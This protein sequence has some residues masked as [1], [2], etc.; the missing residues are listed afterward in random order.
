MITT[1][2]ELRNMIYYNRQEILTAKTQAE[3]YMMKERAEGL[4]RAEDMRFLHTLH[5][6]EFLEQ[7]IKHYNNLLEEKGA[8]R[9]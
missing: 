2:E 1:P 7:G 5:W 6:I 8:E 3:I 4:T 9:V